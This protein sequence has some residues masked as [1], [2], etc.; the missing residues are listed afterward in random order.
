LAVALYGILFRNPFN[1]IAKVDI[2]LLVCCFISCTEIW[3]KNQVKEKCFFTLIKLKMNFKCLFT[4]AIVITACFFSGQSEAQIVTAFAGNNT[5]AGYGGDGGP[6][7][8]AACWLHTPK[9]ITHDAAGNFYFIDADNY[10]IRKI[11]TSGIITT[12][13]GTGYPDTA[14][15]PN[16]TGVPATSVNL[17]QMLGIAVDASGNVYFGEDNY[18]RKITTS[19]MYVNYA[20]IGASGYA[21]DG[22][23][24]TAATI[25]P[26]SLTFDAGG[27]LFFAEYY[28]NCVRKINTTTGIIST[29]AGSGPTGGGYSGDGSAAT[30]AHISHPRDAKFDAAGNLYILDATYGSIRKVS[31]SGVITSVVGNPTSV[32]GYSGDGGPATSARLNSPINMA[33]D[34]TGIIYI[35]DAG[36][37][38]IRRV[39][40]SGIISTFVGNGSWVWNGNGHAGTATTLWGPYGLDVYAG[41][42]YFC[43]GGND[44]IRKI[45][46]SATGVSFLKDDRNNIQL[47]PN[48]NNG[49][50]ILSGTV[51]SSES[52]INVCICDIT[53]KVVYSDF[54]ALID[55]H[56]HTE[57]KLVKSMPSGIYF[58]K[59]NSQAVNSTLKF[60]KE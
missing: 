53:G 45:S 57:I 7:T 55:G 47:S 2:D 32:P 4:S 12:I 35:T 1:I 5:N 51:E 41:N 49:V 37:Q 48:P 54:A 29:V 28:N 44:V 23:P 43:E 38:V 6:A 25:M 33:I 31:A 52:F 10:V 40:T 22:T 3:A 11:N 42:L 19:G 26:V 8:A 56:F 27:N 18:I 59:I 60:L 39:N 17:D 30:S 13:A 20:G 46:T 16:P 24:A 36:N 58:V 15:T 21:G 14:T 50:F 34:A 9:S